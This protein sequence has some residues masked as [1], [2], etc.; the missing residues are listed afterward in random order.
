[1]RGCSLASTKVTC[2]RKENRRLV[3]GCILLS[4]LIA[5]RVKYATSALNIP[6]MEL[7]R[8]KTRATIVSKEARRAS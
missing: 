2:K 4:T 1:M 8:P 7:R 6:V 3:G 5:R